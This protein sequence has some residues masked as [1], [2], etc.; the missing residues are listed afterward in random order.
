MYMM[1]FVPFGILFSI[2]LLSKN[3]YRAQDLNDDSQIIEESNPVSETS[4]IVT[5]ESSANELTESDFSSGDNE[6]S[7]ES[8]KPQSTLRNRV[9]GFFSKFIG[10]ASSDQEPQP[11]QETLPTKSTKSKSLST[12]SLYERANIKNFSNSDNFIFKYADVMV[13]FLANK[14]KQDKKSNQEE[15]SQNSDLVKTSSFSIGRMQVLDFME[16][17]KRDLLINDK[18]YESK[19]LSQKDIE[20]IQFDVEY[21]PNFYS[22]IQKDLIALKK[23]L[24]AYDASTSNLCISF[25]FAFA[26]YHHIFSDLK[27]FEKSNFN[28][29]EMKEI[30][31]ILKSQRSPQ[32]QES[33]II[34]AEKQALESENTVLKNNL[35]AIQL[36]LQQAKTDLSKLESENKNLKFEK[37][38]I[39][40]QYNELE[41]WNE[42]E[43]KELLKV[44]H[45]KNAEL[46]K[47]LSGYKVSDSIRSDQMSEYFRQIHKLKGEIQSLKDSHTSDLYNANSAA[48]DEIKKA[49]DTISSL[50]N[51]IQ[52][53]MEEIQKLSSEL[54]SSGVYINQLKCNLIQLHKQNE[55]RENNIQQNQSSK[56]AD[57]LKKSIEECKQMQSELENLA[58]S[59]MHLK[60]EFKFVVDHTKSLKKEN[61]DLKLEI[62]QLSSQLNAN[63]LSKRRKTSDS[64]FNQIQLDLD[65]LKNVLPNVDAKRTRSSSPISALSSERKSL[66]NDQDYGSALESKN[67][68]SALRSRSDKEESAS[69]RANPIMSALKAPKMEVKSALKSDNKSNQKISDIST[70][71]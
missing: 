12:N 4:D 57:A 23:S 29:P 60:K 36:E 42:D 67:V 24:N 21:D 2:Y 47:E 62:N 14:T 63:K 45:K 17:L 55:E 25:L 43:A 16:L 59:H 11:N 58:H 27:T 49:N 22:N 35:T 33:E 34:H 46:T 68:R 1:L 71:Q 31:S 61:E 52:E 44:Y 9:A 53:L 8:E 20:K 64:K 19:S 40:V 18:Y 54:N 65:S 26:R 13:D 7:T 10:S 32:D 70:M 5:P 6:K 51:H 30:F 37:D 15:P 50:K 3:L 56:Q 41:N 28:L 48:R 69:S 66:S 39:N 38:Q